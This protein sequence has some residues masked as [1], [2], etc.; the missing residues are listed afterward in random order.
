M[1]GAD[2]QQH[3]SA[4]ISSTALRWSAHRTIP[5]SRPT[6]GWPPGS[7]VPARRS[8]VS[9]A[10]VIATCTQ[11][12]TSTEVVSKHRKDMLR[13]AGRAYCSDDCR[14]AWVHKR[15][16]ERMARTNRRYAANRMRANNP[17]HRGD[18]RERMRAT[19]REIG[20]RPP[21]RKGNGLGPSEPQRQL[22]TALGWPMEVAV[23]TGM[24]RGSG[25][26]T[27]YKLDIADPTSKVGIEV[28]GASHG[29]LARKAQDAKKERFL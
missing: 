26:P 25:Y 8:P 21:V 9:A 19:L 13:K 18:A 4:S 7:F 1:S 12:G 24:P 29:L 15:S 17:M 14:D 20:H 11:C 3:S 5:S 28:D 23:R 6:A 22:A 2:Q 10:P 16:S 27:C